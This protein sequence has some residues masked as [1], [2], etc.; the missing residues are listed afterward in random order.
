MPSVFL[1]NSAGKLLRSANGLLCIDSSEDRTLSITSTLQYMDLSS[2][3]VQTPPYTYFTY[4][5]EIALPYA[6][7]PN[8]VTGVFV[9]E[10][11]LW[12]NNTNG[13]SF[14]TRVWPVVK[15]GS[16]FSWNL[17]IYGF[18]YSNSLRYGD[19][20]ISAKLKSLN[21][22]GSYSVDASSYDYQPI[23]IRTTGSYTVS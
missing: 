9:I 18:Y 10:D 4:P 16:A 7:L 3:H 17:L 14:Y 22:L 12:G 11:W 15:N 1:R 13:Q 20:R 6:L 21:P 8:G 19:L 2:G 5:S 23:S